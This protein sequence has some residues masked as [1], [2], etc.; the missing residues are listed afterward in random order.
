MFQLT[1]ALIIAVP[2]I[3]PWPMA[4]TA[5]SPTD[6]PKMGVYYQ[7]AMEYY[8]IH[9]DWE[10]TTTNRVERF[11][12]VGGGPHVIEFGMRLIGGGYS[13]LMVDVPLAGEAYVVSTN[14]IIVDFSGRDKVEFR[15][16]SLPTDDTTCSGSYSNVQ[17]FTTSGSCWGSPVSN[18]GTGVWSRACSG[19]SGSCKS[20]ITY[21]GGKSGPE[22][23][24]A[25]GQGGSV[26]GNTSTN[27][28]FA[29]NAND[30]TCRADERHSQ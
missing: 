16:I 19:S 28:G 7:N 18:P 3:S 27:T 17:S 29:T 2:S 6:E 23:E 21:T 8:L 13:P 30:G 25:C 14:S 11:V 24:F 1:L 5:L 20:E 12:P 9:G 4:P 10:K 22:P 26:S 15:E